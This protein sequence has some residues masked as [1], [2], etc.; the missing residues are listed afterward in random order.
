MHVRWFA[1]SAIA[2][3]LAATLV[4]CGSNDAAP[5][6]ESTMGV[7]EEL[8]QSVL[9]SQDAVALA[10][11]VEIEELISQCMAEQGFE[12]VPVDYRQAIGFDPDA[13]GPL[14]GSPEFVQEYGYGIATNRFEVQEGYQNPNDALFAEM[15]QTEQEAYYTALYGA[16]ALE[17]SEEM[18]EEEWAADLANRG[19]WGQAQD[20]TYG[21]LTDSFADD[22]EA[23]E[24]EMEVLTQQILNDPA[25]VA[26]VGDWASCM[27][28]AGYPD[29]TA[30]EDPEQAI[31]AKNQAVYDDPAFGAATTEEEWAAVNEEVEER[32]ADLAQE[33]I[34]TAVADHDCRESSG[35]NTA[36]G[37][38][39]RKTQQEFYDAHRTEVDAYFEQ[40]AEILGTD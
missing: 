30:I 33:E 24:E 4:G 16:N 3:A 40:L 5:E 39:N 31:T 18:T 29:Y 17:D 10:K 14:P 35:Y 12:Y 2:T 19:C 25:V 7:I 26:A 13:D 36:F 38:V 21:E 15:T 11:Q 27:A 22:W 9:G 6:P 32:L 20:T 1:V 8:A 23:L 28:D 34:A 37:E